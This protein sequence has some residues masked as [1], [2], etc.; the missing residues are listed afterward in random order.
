MTL[1]QSRRENPGFWTKVSVDRIDSSKGY[2]AGNVQL[3]CNW[4]NRAKATLT[5]GEFADFCRLVVARAA[6]S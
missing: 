4:A 6:Q 3:V 5:D 2:I 1:L